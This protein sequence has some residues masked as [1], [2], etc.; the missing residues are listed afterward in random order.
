MLKGQ[1]S[2]TWVPSGRSCSLCPS[3]ERTAESGP[4]LGLVLFFFLKTDF[5]APTFLLL[6]YSTWITC[7]PCCFWQGM[8]DAGEQVSLTLQREFSE[9][10]LNSLAVSPLERAKIYERITNLFK[11]AG[12]TVSGRHCLWSDAA[13]VIQFRETQRRYFFAIRFLRVTWTIPETRTTRGWRRLLSISTMSQVS[14]SFFPVLLNHF[15]F[16]LENLVRSSSSQKPQNNNARFCPAAD[17]SPL[18]P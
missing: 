14:I 11:S 15:Y 1:R 8:V 5:F 16:C 9:E 7:Q 2:S 6:F 18:S 12:F 17:S 13:T 3:K 10:A 4:Y